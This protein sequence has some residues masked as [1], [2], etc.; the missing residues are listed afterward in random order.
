MAVMMLVCGAISA[1]T[2]VTFTAGTDMSE[3][4]TLTKDGIT[5]TLK[6]G[7]STSGL[8]KLA[9]ED[10]LRAISLLYLLQLVTLPI[11]SSLVLLIIP[12]SM[13]LVALLLRT[14]IHLK[15]R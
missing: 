11:L 3:G 10:Y 7:T 13:V 4:A 15:I 8:G 9:T 12:L 5:L 14:A 1:Q 2:V 6:E